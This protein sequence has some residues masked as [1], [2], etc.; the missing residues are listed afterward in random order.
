MT[1]SEIPADER[2]ERCDDCGI[3]TSEHYQCG[4][5]IEQVEDIVDQ[6]RESYERRYEQDPEFRRAEQERSA[7]ILAHL[8]AGGHGG[9][10][11]ILPEIPAGEP[12]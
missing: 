12:F 11:D 2:E 8:R 7:R 9:S 6:R 1:T 3:P 10:H 4:L 5:T